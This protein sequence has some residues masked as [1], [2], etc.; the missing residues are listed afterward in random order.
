MGR[1]RRLNHRWE[2]N[3]LPHPVERCERCGVVRA[4]GP[5]MAIWGGQCVEYT[6]PAGEVVSRG[7][8]RAAPPPICDPALYEGR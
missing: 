8:R 2:K 6:T 1:R 4:T 5:F 7:P 3:D